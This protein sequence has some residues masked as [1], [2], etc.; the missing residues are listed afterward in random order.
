MHETKKH[1]SKP[2]KVLFYGKKIPKPNGFGIFLLLKNNDLSLGELGSTTSCFET[3]LLSFLHSGVTGEKASLLQSG[4]EC[5]C[6]CLKK[7]SGNTVTDGTSLAGD[8]AAD[9]I[10]NDIKLAHIAGEFQGLT[11]DELEGIKTEIVIDISLID[12]DHA[13][14][15]INT[16]TGDGFLSSAGAVEIRFCTSVIHGFLPFFLIRTQSSGAAEQR[17]DELRRHKLSNE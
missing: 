15:G 5:F 1:L 9:Y 11:N 6:I 12:G 14:T 17:A 16:N 7:S 8:T 10:A 13:G 4:T 3:V 2:G